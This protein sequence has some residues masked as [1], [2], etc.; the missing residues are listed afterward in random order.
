MR[1]PMKAMNHKSSKSSNMSIVNINIDNSKIKS[2]RADRIDLPKLPLHNNMDMSIG[3]DELML[4]T[5]K[6]GMGAAEETTS[7]KIPWREML[8]LKR[9]KTIF[10]E[11]KAAKET[12]QSEG[13]TV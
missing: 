12:I 11:K 4:T 6:T 10:E 1:I 9:Q 5:S 8:E 3:G 13:M 7:T 2:G